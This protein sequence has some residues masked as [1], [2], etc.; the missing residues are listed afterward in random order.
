MQYQQAFTGMISIKDL[1]ELTKVL[2]P[3]SP[4]IK[5]TL[6]YACNCLQA[7]CFRPVRRQYQI[8]APTW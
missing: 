1:I 3:L 6:I 5:I 8:L 7:F 4:P 2:I